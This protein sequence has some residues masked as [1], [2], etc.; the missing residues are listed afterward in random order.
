MSLILNMGVDA[1]VDLRKLLGKGA[2]PSFDKLISSLALLAVSQQKAVIDA[3][4]KWRKEMVEPLDASLIKRISE[5]APLSRTREVQSVLKERQSLA[6][7]YILCRSL[8]DIVR[9]FTA[10]AFLDD[11]GE[12]LEKIVFAQLKKPDPDRFI[13]ELEKYNSHTIMKERQS[14]MEML[15]RG[16]RFLK[17]KLC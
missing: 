11:L 14:H 2:D 6:S 17:I 10:G 7:V 13:A 4:M 5:S 16:M 12:N 9:R 1:E 15:I 8:I 3:V